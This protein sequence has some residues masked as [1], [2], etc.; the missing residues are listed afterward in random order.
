M[1]DYDFSK[2]TENS[3]Y[4]KGA[5]NDML[6]GMKELSCK[7]DT[8]IALLQ[9]GATARLVQTEQAP[10]IQSPLD[11]IKDALYSTIRGIDEAE[12]DK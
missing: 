6:F 10:N 5:L 12:Q 7:L 9:V 2:L 1:R 4:I 3:I 8:V 11:V